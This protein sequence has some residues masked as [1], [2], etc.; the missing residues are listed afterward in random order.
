MSMPA[1]WYKTSDLA[2]FFVVR[3]EYNLVLIM[4]LNDLWIKASM[5][6]VFDFYFILISS[7]L[8]SFATAGFMVPI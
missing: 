2:H 6:N 8:K 3:F 7:S 4:H 1:I 5:C